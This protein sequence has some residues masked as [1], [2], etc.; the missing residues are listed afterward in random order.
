MFHRDIIVVTVIS[1]PDIKIHKNELD[2]VGLEGVTVKS[3]RAVADSKYRHHRDQIERS[4]LVILDT[5]D[6]PK[7]CLA[8]QKRNLREYNS[9]LLIETVNGREL[10]PIYEKIKT[11]LPLLRASS[12]RLSVRDEKKERLEDLIRSF[13]SSL[14]IRGEVDLTEANAVLMPYGFSCASSREGDSVKISIEDGRSAKEKGSTE[15][16]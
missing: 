4:D 10:E 6:M 14:K 11:A 15:K 7:Q 1:D 5:Q 16:C 13:I 12:D 2:K 9:N 3:I 8:R